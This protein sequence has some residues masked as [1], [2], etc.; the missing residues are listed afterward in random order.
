MKNELAKY[1]AIET[2]R[3]IVA[4]RVKA[5]ADMDIHQ[6]LDEFVR[7]TGVVNANTTRDEDGR[8]E[9]S[10]AGFLAIKERQV[11]ATLASARFGVSLASD[12]GSYDQTW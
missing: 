6:L 3:T 2:Y 8:P 7:L 4:D 9:Y 12:D 5:A 11:F 1:S 10:E